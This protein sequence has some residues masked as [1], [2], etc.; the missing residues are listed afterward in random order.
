MSIT[1]AAALRTAKAPAESNPASARSVMTA[2]V[3]ASAGAAILTTSIAAIAHRAG[4]SFA[5][6]TGAAIP[7]SG[8]ATLTVL[9][10]VLGV[11]LALLLRRRARRPRPTF[12]RITGVLLVLS[13][14]PDLLS[15]FTAGATATLILTHLAAAAI[16]IPTLAGRLSPRR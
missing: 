15:G 5:D 4:V 9:F 1:T 14:G 6:R 7:L 12:V 11:G 8:F 13:F 2:G 10:S 16:V 3:L